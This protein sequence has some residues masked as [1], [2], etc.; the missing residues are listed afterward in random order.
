MSKR[1]W[2][3]LALHFTVAAALT[4][5]ILWWH[6]FIVLATFI[7]AWLREQAQHRYDL[8]QIVG[9]YPPNVYAVKKS[10]FFGWMTWWRMFEVAQWTTGSAVV[11][12]AY[13]LWSRRG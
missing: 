2:L 1:D 9:T 4:A 10:T 3:Y 12:L 11:C 13:E 8:A 6:W 5:L 7:Y